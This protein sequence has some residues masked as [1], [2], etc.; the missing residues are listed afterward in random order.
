[1]TDRGA[2][3]AGRSIVVTP[4]EG[5]HVG[6]PSAEVIAAA[7]AAA[8]QIVRQLAGVELA[9]AKRPVNVW[10]F[11]GRDWDG[12]IPLRRSRPLR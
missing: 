12:P 7:V 3:G 4:A 6:S 8:E 11:S 1:M 5:G 2:H 9:A 10:R